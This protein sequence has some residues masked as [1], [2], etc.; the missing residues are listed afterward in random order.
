MVAKESFIVNHKVVITVKNHQSL[1][2]YLVTS[3]EIL[4]TFYGNHENIKQFAKAI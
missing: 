3:S 2:L 1:K 4:Q